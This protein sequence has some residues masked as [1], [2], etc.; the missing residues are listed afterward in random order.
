MTLKR[1]GIFNIILLEINLVS[2]VWIIFWLD[3]VI[4]YTS[5]ATF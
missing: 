4:Y 5:I 1:Y 2:L 3:T